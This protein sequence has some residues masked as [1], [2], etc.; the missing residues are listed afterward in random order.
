MR[1]SSIW[2]TT[3]SGSNIFGVFLNNSDGVNVINIILSDTNLL[4]LF[5]RKLDIISAADVSGSS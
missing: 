4:L 5:M 1:L 3:L 2:I